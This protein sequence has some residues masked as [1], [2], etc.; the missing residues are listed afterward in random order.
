MTADE[1]VTGPGG[2]MTL[3]SVRSFLRFFL[4]PSSSLL[5]PKSLILAP[6]IRISRASPAHLGIARR[7]PRAMTGS[8]DRSH[9]QGAGNPPPPAARRRRVLRRRTEPQAPTGAK[10]KQ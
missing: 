9:G 2:P 4:L 6:S 8:R 5:L 7:R 10:K 1:A 3:G